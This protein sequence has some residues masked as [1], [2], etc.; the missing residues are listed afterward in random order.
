MTSPILGVRFEGPP[1][2]GTGV[3]GFGVDWGRKVS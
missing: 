3:G 2:L 1:G